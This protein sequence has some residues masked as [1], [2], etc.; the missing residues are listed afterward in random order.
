MSVY[1]P[2]GAGRAADGFPSRSA[3]VA[4]ILERYYEGMR[5][6]QIQERFSEMEL[7]VLLQVMTGWQPAS[8]AAVFGGLLVELRDKNVGPPRLRL[9]LEALNALE[10]LALVEWLEERLRRGKK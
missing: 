10:E 8:A 5:R 3:R 7:E 2:E 4:E 1:L 6:M 9:K